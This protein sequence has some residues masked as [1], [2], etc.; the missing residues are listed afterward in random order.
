MYLLCSVSDPCRYISVH[1]LTLLFVTHRLLTLLA[2]MRVRCPVSCMAQLQSDVVSAMSW[3]M[4]LQTTFADDTQA[5]SLKL[6]IS[7]ILCNMLW[8]QLVD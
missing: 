4:Q 8:Y 5:M 3:S 7:T 1:L 6:Y 2:H